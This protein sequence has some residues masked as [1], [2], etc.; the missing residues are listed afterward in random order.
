ME[1][2]R[3]ASHPH[4]CHLPKGVGFEELPLPSRERGLRGGCFNVALLMIVLVIMGVRARLFGKEKSI[5][6]IR[7]NI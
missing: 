3:K 1:F 4:P 7:R 6:A 5:V 2:I